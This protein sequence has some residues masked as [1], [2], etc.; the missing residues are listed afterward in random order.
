MPDYHEK[1]WDLS[2]KYDALAAEL[3]A[4]KEN[5]RRGWE[6]AGT[7]RK[8]YAELRFPGMTGEVHL[9]SETAGFDETGLS[10]QSDYDQSGR[11]DKETKEEHAIGGNLISGGCY[12]P[13]AERCPVRGTNAPH[14]Q[15]TLNAGHPGYHVL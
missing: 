6:L 7:W 12:E 9:A 2:Q 5:A 13:K 3:A 4:E 10:Q 8:K 11:L 1:Y 14:D 15:C